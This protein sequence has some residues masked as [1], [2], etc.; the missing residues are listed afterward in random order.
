LSARRSKRSDQRGQEPKTG[1]SV[2]SKGSGTKNGTFGHI[3]GVRNQKPE[4]RFLARSPD[5]DQAANHFSALAAKQVNFKDQ[6][7][8]PFVTIRLFLSHV[9][10]PDHSC[11]ASIQPDQK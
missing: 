3:K 10:D 6:I 11:R 7:Y 4:F 8:T 5:A 9:L 1:L 2:T